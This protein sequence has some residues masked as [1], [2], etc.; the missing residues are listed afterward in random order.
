M[1]IVTPTIQ[2]NAFTRPAAFRSGDGG[3]RRPAGSRPGF[4]RSAGCDARVSRGVRIHSVANDATG[5]GVRIHR[6]AQ[7]GVRI[8]SGVRIHR[9][10]GRGVR[11]HAGV[12]IH[13]AHGVPT[14]DAV[15]RG[16]RIHSTE[17]GVR[18][19]SVERGVRIHALTAGVRIHGAA[20]RGVRI[21][22]DVDRGV[23]IHGEHRAAAFAM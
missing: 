16:V 11:I 1:R 2:S 4:D 20:E 17:R 5:R 15:D 12:R 3:A 13:R 6:E 19:H 14:A 23:R 9:T 21:H 7:R 18:I 22:G 10:D 8:H